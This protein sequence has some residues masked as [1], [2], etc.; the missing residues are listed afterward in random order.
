ATLHACQN[1]LNWDGTRYDLVRVQD[2]SPW[3]QC[4]YY[5]DNGNGSGAGTYCFYKGPSYDL[6]HYPNTPLRADSNPVCPTSAP[7]PSVYRIR[8]FVDRT[9]CITAAGEDDG[10][11]TCRTDIWRPEQVFHFDGNLIKPLSTD[12]CLDVKDGN[13]NNGTQLQ[14]WT[15]STA[16]PNQLFEHFSKEMLVIPD[17][18]IN[19]AAQPSLC[20]DLTDSNTADGT[21]IQIWGC[22]HPN[23]NQ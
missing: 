14:I 23:P 9:K 4:E 6:V 19:W 20:F 16:N 3:I 15:C 11:P 18:Y 5:H 17:D 21:P 12:K 10:A 22:D 7:P 13:T 8:S 2:M 1:Y